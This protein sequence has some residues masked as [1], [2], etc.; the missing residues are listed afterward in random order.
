MTTIYARTGGF[1]CTNCERTNLP[2][3]AMKRPA[4]RGLFIRC[5]FCAREF[6]L[7]GHGYWSDGIHK[8]IECKM[9]RPAED[10][11]EA[12][13]EAKAVKREGSAR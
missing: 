7:T 2:G 5:G 1:T 9:E 12:R 8:N 13:S 3:Y 10:D 6:H 4:G 11:H